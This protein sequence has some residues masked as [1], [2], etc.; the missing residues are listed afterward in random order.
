MSGGDLQNFPAT[1]DSLNM[2]KFIV[3]LSLLFLGGPSFGEWAE[4]KEVPVLLM[5]S[6]G[7]ITVQADGTSEEVFEQT[8][9]AVNEQGRN[10][11][12]LQKIPFSPDTTK[13]KVLS[14]STKNDGVETAVDLKTIQERTSG[15]DKQGLSGLKEL[16]IPFTNLRNGSLVKYKFKMTHFK[17]LLP[18]WYTIRFVYGLEFPEMGGSVVVR[19]KND[20]KH[21]TLDPDHFLEVKETIE[22][23][24]TVVRIKQL[25]PITRIPKDEAP[26][27]DFRDIPQIQMTTGNSWQEYAAT[28]SAKYEKILAEKNLPAAFKE[29]VK[30]AAT[31]KDPVEKI[32]VV[33]SELAST[34]TYSGNW[35]SSEKFYVA[36]SL[37]D[38]GTQKIG[39]CKD[40][41]TA[42]TA[43]L[44][45]LGLTADVAF[46]YR[47]SS[48]DPYRFVLSQPLNQSLPMPFLFNHAIVRVLL[49]AGKTLWVDPTNIVSN[50]ATIF[51]DIAGAPALVI[52]KS[53]Q[54]LETTPTS[55]AEENQF[56]SEKT[57][58]VNSDDTVESQV[59]TEMTG[60]YAKGV[61]ETALNENTDKAKYIVRVLAGIYSKDPQVNFDNVNLQNRLSKS[62]KIGFK[63]FGEKT[64]TEKDGKRYIVI[65]VP[66]RSQSYFGI[67]RERVTHVYAGEESLERHVTKVEGYD[68]KGDNLGCEVLSA[69]YYLRRKLIKTETGFEVQDYF[70]AKN[71]IISVRDANDD[72]FQLRKSSIANCDSAIEIEKI[73]AK[74]K[75]ADRLKDYNLEKITALNEVY[76]AGSTRSCQVAVHRAEQLLIKNPKDKELRIQLLKAYRHVGF[77]RSDVSDAEY[78]R[79][80]DKVLAGLFRD[81]PQ[82]GAVLRQKVF[83]AMNRKSYPEMSDY[84]KKAYYA[85]EKGYDIYYLGGQVAT[86]L[87]SAKAAE[88]S[89]FKAISMTKK[90][91]EISRAYG[92]LARI[93]EKDDKKKHLEYLKKAIDYDPENGWLRSNL[94]GELNQLERWDEAVEVGEK[95]LKVS[96]FGVGRRQLGQAYAG[97]A[98]SIFTK[99]QDPTSLNQAEDACGKGMKIHPENEQCLM[100]L[101]KVNFRLGASTQDLN[102][103]QKSIDYFKQGQKYA[104]QGK[105]DFDPLIQQSQVLLDAFN[106]NARAPA[107]EK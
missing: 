26:L 85:S 78:D 32:D 41:A 57:I 72:D 50:A 31:K 20:I 92:N 45:N 51:P 89:F 95:M 102:R 101:G 69:W 71:R 34:M 61:I 52:S 65:P 39:D 104:R 53:T 91:V 96:D 63:T 33:T 84:F 87:G 37:K 7:E 47:G 6:S 88:N 106:H 18:G 93:F 10:F 27:V 107:S 44:R 94:L 28:M 29:I 17:P 99:S 23:G 81:F 48:R 54:N 8:F 2:S 38:I 90:P 49:G 11:L 70:E 46:I 68:F 59:K 3:L 83:S 5:D 73:P 58:R 36:K 40:F 76:G 15:S 13:V 16:V 77:V 82:D 62:I 66:I 64:I 9:K 67:G 74:T 56:I 30:K 19:S 100:L 86:K 12:A 1:S 105:A 42:T 24:W 75:L 14:A 35:T 25:K 4:E 55:K 103:L 43:M 22:K 79:E 98:N 80:S 21:V 97:K 60:D